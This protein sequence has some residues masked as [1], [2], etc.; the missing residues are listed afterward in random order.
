V[1]IV[2]VGCDEHACVKLFNPSIRLC[3][4]WFQIALRIEAQKGQLDREVV[5]KVEKMVES[6]LLKDA[7]RGETEKVIEEH[8]AELAEILSK[9][10]PEE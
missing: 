8:F 10:K 9:A 3:W 7:P 1:G 6:R 5:T 4:N 2:Q